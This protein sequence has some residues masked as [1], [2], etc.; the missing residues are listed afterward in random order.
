MSVIKKFKPVYQC[1]LINQGV[2]L[3]IAVLFGKGRNSY[4]GSI[5]VKNTSSSRGSS[6]L[7]SKAKLIQP[8]IVLREAVLSAMRE[9]RNLLAL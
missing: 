3:E 7:I 5:R 1:W 6:K 2:M 4:H 8:K 9:K